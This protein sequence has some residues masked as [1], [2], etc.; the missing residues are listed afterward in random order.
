MRMTPSGPYNLL[1]Y[2]LQCLTAKIFLR[3]VCNVKNF[4]NTFIL[5][6]CGLSIFYLI[7][8]SS[9]FRRVNNYLNI[10]YYVTNSVEFATMV[11]IHWVP[12]HSLRWLPV[13]HRIQEATLCFK[14]VKPGTTSYLNNTLKPYA[15]LRALRSSNM[16]LLTVPRTDTSLGLRR[17]SAAGPQVW[18]Q[19]PHKLHQCNTISSFKSNL[20]TH[21]FRRHMDN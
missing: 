4:I 1:F 7:N 14:A 15:P 8:V 3:G 13:R 9:L 19:L 10:T 17:F 6:G 18:N 2:R 16:D 21:Y 11:V 20:K 12:I 5:W